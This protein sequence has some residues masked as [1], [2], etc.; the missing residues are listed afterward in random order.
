M[1]TVV[2]LTIGTLLGF[3]IG[4]IVMRQRDVRP[5]GLQA[6][7]QTQ[8]QV[9]K[10]GTGTRDTNDPLG[11]FGG[12][13]DEPRVFKLYDGETVAMTGGCTKPMTITLPSGKKVT[14]PE[15]PK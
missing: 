5:T 8:T 4:V 3:V 2:S 6:P 15:P 14:I 13:S 11:L 12:C 1:K 10:G 9:E 7:V